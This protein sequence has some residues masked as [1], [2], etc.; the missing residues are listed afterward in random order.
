MKPSDHNE[1]TILRSVD[2]IPE[3]A[4]EDEEREWWGT[5]ELAPE[6]GE[7]GTERHRALVK[8]WRRRQTV[9]RA[10]HTRRDEVALG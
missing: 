4:S 3:F 10:G 9:Q 2:D 1:R 6:L 7:N 5:H 8:R